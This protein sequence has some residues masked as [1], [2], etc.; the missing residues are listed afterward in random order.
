MKKIIVIPI[1]LF[2]ICAIS[3]KFTKQQHYDSAAKYFKIYMRYS[4]SIL[5]YQYK[6]RKLTEYYLRK[7]QEL[8]LISRK[9]VEQTN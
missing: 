3:Q 8:E 9:H 7:Q 1:L 5:K 2:S 4:D 6:N